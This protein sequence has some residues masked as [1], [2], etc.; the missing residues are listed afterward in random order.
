MKLAKPDLLGGLAG[1][2]QADRDVDEADA[3]TA[4][5][6]R[7]R[8]S[9]SLPQAPAE[10]HAGP[11]ALDGW[12]LQGRPSLLGLR[13]PLRYTSPRKHWRPQPVT[14]DLGERNFGL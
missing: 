14:N 10:G 12:G 9:V 7:A 6:D 8:H 5:P 1:G 11:T 3:D 13:W 4:F 2:V